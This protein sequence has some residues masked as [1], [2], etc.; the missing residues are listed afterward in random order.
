MLSNCIYPWLA[1]VRIF[2]ASILLLLQRLP[3][4]AALAAAL[5]PRTSRTYLVGLGHLHPLPPQFHVSCK[6]FA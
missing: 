3:L 6:P 4:A 1:M 5:S 2:A